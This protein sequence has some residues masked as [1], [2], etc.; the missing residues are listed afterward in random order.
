MKY[1]NALVTTALLVLALTG[2]KSKID[3]VSGYYDYE[4]ECVSVDRNGIQTVKA[5]G[6]GRTEKEA[7]LNARRRAV[8]DIL[9][10]GLRGG[11]RGCNLRPLIANPNTRRNQ[12]QYFFRFFGENGPFETYAG[13]PDE[14]WL[15]QKLKINK[16]NKHNLAYEV[17]I[18]VDVM[19]L[20]NHLKR[21]Q[22]IQ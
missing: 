21:D 20:K 7:I 10:K 12:E 9:F 8:D 17:V 19:G 18:E 11:S 1:L 14:N 3:T 4:T 15:R 2:C 13:L 6:T 5:W 22:I 16:K